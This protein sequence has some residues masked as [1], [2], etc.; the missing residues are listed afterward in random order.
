MMYNEF[1]AWS[2]QGNTDEFYSSMRWQGWEDDAKNTTINSAIL[3]YPF[4]WAKECDL[5]KASKK[6]INLDEIIE[7]NYPRPKG[8]WLVPA[9][10]C[11][12]S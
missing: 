3:I 4:L 12:R 11:E 10:S 5:E 8:R 9:Q 6:I 2:L 7:V 1:L